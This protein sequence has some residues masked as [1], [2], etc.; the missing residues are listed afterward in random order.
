[1][2]DTNVRSVLAVLAD[3]RL[4]T[5]GQ[6]SVEVAHE[7]LIREWPRLREWLNQD[8]ISLRLHRQLTQSA[9]DWEGN[10]HDVG[11]VF[12]GARLAQAVEWAADHESE[13]TDL[14]RT[15]LHAS[16]ELAQREASEHEAQRQRELE[17]ARRL[18]AT[19]RRASAQLRQ[20]ALLLTVAFVITLATSGVAAFLGDQAR[21]NAALAETNARTA[22]ARELASSAAANLDVDPERSILLA[23]Q[24]VATTTSDVVPEPEVENALHRSVE[25]SRTRLTIRG[26]TDRVQGV[27]FSPDGRHLVSTGADRTARVCYTFTVVQS[28]LLSGQT[29]EVD[30]PAYSPDGALIATPSWDRTT[31]IWDASSGALVRTLEGHTDQVRAA[32]FSPDGTHLV[33]ASSDATARIWDVSTGRQLGT[34]L[35][36]AEGLLGVAYSPNGTRIATASRDRT[37][38]VWDAASGERLATLS[39]HESEVISVAFSP[40]G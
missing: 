13:L 27:A 21:R 24:A 30:I 40:D 22:Y 36:H 18:A 12:R 38:A 34:P 17:A 32:T 19:E 37:A 5:L 1:N 33:T 29:D 11:M 10:G 8:R 9:K 14:E 15:F 31:R 4:V 25:A 35:K 7:A 26:H 2:E 20:R 3:A 39:G 16:R 6:D 23:L 28:L